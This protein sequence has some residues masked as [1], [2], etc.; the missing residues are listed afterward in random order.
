MNKL[1]I[2]AMILWLTMLMS[3]I[4][5]AMAQTFV[6]VDKTPHDIVY[7]R[8]EG[9]VKPQIKV[10]YGRPLADTNEIFGKDI[11]YGKIW[12]TGANEATEIK[13]Y[14]DVMF[15]NKF[16]KAGTY[17]LYTIPGENYWTVILNS[18]TDSL[19]AFFNHESKDCENSSTRQ[20]SHARQK[21]LRLLSI[22]ETMK[23]NSFWP[24]V[25]PELK[26]RYI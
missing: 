15:A 13:F 16:I 7:F 8:S 6:P 5:L 25:L 23:R 9:N 14:Q 3:F 10:V 21:S 24:G 18:N 12:R 4:N 2:F 19:G 1:K 22:Q 20:R 26:C 11:P 17:A